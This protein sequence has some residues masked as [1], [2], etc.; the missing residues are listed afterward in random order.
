MTIDLATKSDFRHPTASTWHAPR[1]VADGGGGT[2]IATAEI[3]MSPE[4]VFRALTTK[5]VERW[6]GSP[7]SYRQTAWSAELR[8]CGP[9]S[10]TVRFA[11]GSVNY[12]SGE[13][14]EIDPH[15]RSS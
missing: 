3:A 13:F 6:W 2:V 9:W 1:A 11:D 14:L 15:A 5:E 4:R 12:G 7:E 10:V 8:V